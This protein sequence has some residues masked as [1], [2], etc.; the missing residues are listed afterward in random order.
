MKYRAGFLSIILL[1]ALW[2]VSLGAAQGYEVVEVKNGATLKG[3]VSFSGSL[4]P[5]EKNVITKDVEYCGKEQGAGKYIVYDSRVKNAVVWL[6]GVAKGKVLPEKSV[7]ITIK[8]CITEPHVGIGFVGG[9]YR[10][11]NEDEILHTIQLKLGLAYQKRVSER[12]VKDG[13]TIYNLALPL[14]D[15][16][17]DKPIKNYHKYSEETGFIRIRSNTHNSI[18]GYI[19][20]FDHPYAAVTDGNG[21]FVMDNI[22]PG[23]YILKVW[24]EGFGIQEKKV[25]VSSG[26]FVEIN[27]A[28]EP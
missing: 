10:F 9:A 8:N 17:I 23:E 14:K 6:E 18:R 25:K 12:P 15:A 1:A 20:I 27:I 5:E 13:A 2:T 11:K 19:F 28:F 21:A 16:Q 24:H 22:P 7:P 4:P 3:S 26:E